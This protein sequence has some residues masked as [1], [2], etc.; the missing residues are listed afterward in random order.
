MIRI[1]A[2][3]VI[4]I[5]HSTLK[6]TASKLQTF[7]LY[8]LLEDKLLEISNSPD[9]QIAGPKIKSRECD[10]YQASS[11]Q[12]KIKLAVKCYRQHT[13]QVAAKQQFDALQ[14]CYSGLVDQCDN[15][16]V[17]EPFH[18]DTEHRILLMEWITGKSLHFYLWNPLSYPNQLQSLLR[19]AGRWLRLFHNLSLKEAQQSASSSFLKGISKQKKAYQENRDNN[20][21]C[22]N[23]FNHAYGL[24]QQ[25]IS[26]QP[27]F[28]GPHALPHGD[29]TPANLILSNTQTSAL[30]LWGSTNRP[31]HIDMARMVTYLTIAYPLLTQRPLFDTQGKIQQKLFPLFTSYGT[32]VLDPSAHNFKIALLSEYL[33]RWLV[34]SH[35]KFSYKGMVTDSFQILQIKKQVRVLISAL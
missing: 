22:D 3:H 33:R 28:H 15:F 35:R 17:P 20:A 1:I 27:H 5:S 16:R 2:V 32:D 23:V 4:S 26:L 34:I 21:S 24:L 10:I 13:N 11:A 25:I 9:W 12:A 7:E 6:H 30:D 8:S 19:K 18:C 14:K 31:I 29:F